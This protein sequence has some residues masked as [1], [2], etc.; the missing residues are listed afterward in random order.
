MDGPQ[1]NT[2]T[3]IDE[4]QRKAAAEAEMYANAT[5]LCVHM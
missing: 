3:F 2:S 1:W 4:H 5:M